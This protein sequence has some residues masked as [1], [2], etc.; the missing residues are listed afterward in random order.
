VASRVLLLTD[1]RTFIEAAKAAFAAERYYITPL[2]EDSSSGMSFSAVS[3][4]S[5]GPG[6][7][8]SMADCAMTVHLHTSRKLSGTRR[9]SKST[10]PWSAK[11]HFTFAL[12][13]FCNV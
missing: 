12:L 3:T 8:L 13:V 11:S 10:S 7:I 6:G 2:V 1:N 5:F 4:S 9:E